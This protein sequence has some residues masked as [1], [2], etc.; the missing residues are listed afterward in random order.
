MN[1]FRIVDIDQG[2]CRVLYEARNS[3]DEKVYY[4][5][6]QEGQGMG[7][8]FYRCSGSPWFEPSHPVKIRD[9]ACISI[10]APHGDSELERAVYNH[11]HATYGMKEASHAETH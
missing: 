1:V 6:Q 4:C 10:E 9:G 5:I 11:I 3:N 7:C 2:F 8:V